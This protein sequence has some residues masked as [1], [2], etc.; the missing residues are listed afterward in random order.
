MISN[1]LVEFKSGN[2]ICSN[3]VLPELIRAFELQSPVQRSLTPKW[4]LSWVLICLQKAPY[5]P[6]H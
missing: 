5:E 6:L 2:R 1:T 4:D 3:P